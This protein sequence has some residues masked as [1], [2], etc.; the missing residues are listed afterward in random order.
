[1]T[2]CLLVIDAQESF[3]HRPYFHPA[4]LPRYLA[5][6]N[7]LILGCAALGMPIVRVFHHDPGG[8]AADPFALA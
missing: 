6:Q 3:V 5:A 1:M 8:D 2:S 7:A 4:P